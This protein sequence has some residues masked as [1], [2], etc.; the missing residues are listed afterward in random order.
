M[1]ALE[2]ACFLVRVQDL[3]VI[4]LSLFQLVE[5]V[6]NEEYHQEWEHRRE[7][8][9]SVAVVELIEHLL[10]LILIELMILQFLAALVHKIK[11]IG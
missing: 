5:E 1:K 4:I 2:Y 11:L 9:E 3:V 6:R 8:Y 7:L 10:M